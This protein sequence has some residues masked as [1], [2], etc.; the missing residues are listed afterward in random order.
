MMHTLPHL[1]L[2]LLLLLPAMAS[3]S[4]V[5]MASR[6]PR[7][8][9][10]PSPSDEVRVISSG[11]AK[12]SGAE[13]RVLMSVKEGLDPGGLLLPSWIV[14]GGAFDGVQWNAQGRVS[15]ISLQGKGLAG[16]I[17]S[18]IAELASLTALSL[19]HNRLQ[20]SI[21]SVLYKLSALTH[22]YLDVNLLSGRIPA[23]LGLLD[24]L[25]G[26]SPEEEEEEEVEEEEEEAL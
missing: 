24:R 15:N 2:L 5:A 4:S 18:A 8:G 1:V 16:S 11:A 3:S 26:K 6:I 21:P 25:Q 13:I 9:T 10:I 17:P 23:E 7:T 20:G 19:H 22:L 12:R 14:P